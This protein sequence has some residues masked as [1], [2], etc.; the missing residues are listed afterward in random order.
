MTSRAAVVR[1]L[2]PVLLGALAKDREPCV[3]VGR[4]DVGDEACLEALAQTIFQRLE[5]AWRAIG[6]EHQL[7][8]RL[9]GGC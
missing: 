3:D 9:R 1:E 7:S 5:V 8:C 2:D 4:A 6:G